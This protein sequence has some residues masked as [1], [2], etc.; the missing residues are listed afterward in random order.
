MSTSP[1][2]TTPPATAT[3]TAPA[4]ATP[5]TPTGTPPAPAAGTAVAT[6]RTAPATPALVHPTPTPRLLR[7]LRN[8]L[9]AVLLLFTGLTVVATVAPELALGASAADIALGQQLR[10]AR[11]TLVEADRKASVAFLAPEAAGSS[12]EWAD[13]QAT[14]DQVS[15]MLLRAAADQPADADQLATVQTQ[16]SDY[17]RSVDAAWTVAVTG[18]A[19]GGSEFVAAGTKLDAPLQTLATLAQQSDARVGTGPSWQVGPWAV[20]AGWVAVAT[21]VLS[22][23]LVARRAH[24]VLN[25]GLGAGLILVVAAVALA[26]QA[27]GVVQRALTDVTTSSLVSARVNADTRTIAEQAKA[28]EDRTLLQSSRGDTE[29]TQLSAQ[30]TTALGTLPDA[31][32]RNLQ[33]TA[34]TA[35]TSA[36]ASVNATAATAKAQGRTTTLTPLVAFTDAA[37]GLADADTTVAT[38]TLTT[39]QRSQLPFGAIASVAALLALFASV[40]GLGRRLA[41]YA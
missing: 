4:P 16:I 33:T 31:S 20:A 35:Y 7:R 18:S 10:G 5:P 26:G 12:G 32:E 27:N 14:I 19:A 2:P 25:V 15:S 9:V 38:S 22:S 36:H 8:A 3:A 28:A 6:T 30:L 39:A 21:L 37:K 40:S 29:W 34:W 1:A 13:Y 11:A 23:I 24:R 41:E 17:R